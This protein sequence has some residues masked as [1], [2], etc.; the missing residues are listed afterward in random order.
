MKQKFIFEHTGTE[1]T[2]MSLGIYVYGLW[3]VKDPSNYLFIMSSAVILPYH[4]FSV[5]RRVRLVKKKPILQLN[6][7]NDLHCCNFGKIN[8]H[9]VTK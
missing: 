1:K 2:Q 6:Y 9:L 7:M 8:Y 3:I 5:M 4:I